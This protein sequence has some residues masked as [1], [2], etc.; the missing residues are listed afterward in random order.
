MLNTTRP[1]YYP[2]TQN[3][4]PVM[5]SRFL[6]K[7][8]ISLQIIQQFFP[9]KYVYRMF[10]KAVLE[11]AVK[12][13]GIACKLCTTSER[14]QNGFDVCTPLDVAF[15]TTSS[16]QCMLE[17]SYRLF[18]TSNSDGTW[19]TLSV[20]ILFTSKREYVLFLS[21]TNKTTVPGGGL[22]L[23]IQLSFNTVQYNNGFKRVF[24]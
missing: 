14:Y 5:Y 3:A 11:A 24:S 7:F 21:Y 22:I 17:T 4:V 16:V 9:R 10:L 18:F 13:N 6:G 19:I 15:C 23:Q 1:Y 2:N 12:Q 20:I 8:S